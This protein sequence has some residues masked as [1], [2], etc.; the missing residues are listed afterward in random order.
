MLLKAQLLLQEERNE[1][2]GEIPRRVPNRISE[3][4]SACLPPSVVIRL[5]SSKCEK[6]DS[7]I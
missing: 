2:R 4:V 5:N 1:K 7:L 3:V 6:Y